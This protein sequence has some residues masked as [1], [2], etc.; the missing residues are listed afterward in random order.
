MLTVGPELRGGNDMP[1][2]TAAFLENRRLFHSRDVD[3]TRAWLRGKEFRFDLPGRRTVQPD[4]RVNGVYLPNMYLGYLQYG[5]QAVVSAAPTRS[6]YWVH[7]PIRGSLDASFGGDTIACHPQRAVILSPTR[8]N[9]N[10]M[11]LNADCSRVHIYFHRDALL[12]QLTALLGEPVDQPVEFD[13]ELALTSGYGRSLASCLLLAVSDFEQSDA[14]LE[15]PIM[16]TMF[17]QFIL[18]G[19]L[20]AHAHSCS[21]RLRRRE[22]PIFP[23]DVKRAIDYM[24]SNLDAPLTLS[25][26]VAAAGV[27]GRTLFKH[28]EDWKGVSPMRYLRNVR[29]QRAREALKRGREG[30]SVTEV[31]KS[32]GFNHMSRFSAEYRK[33]FGESPSKTLGRRRC[34]RDG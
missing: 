7:L 5:V 8:D 9:Y 12:R 4:V 10:S 6:D 3:E 23:R 20:L 21:E 11:Q 16:M 18:T 30:T 25:D 26:I 1:S 17:E 31:A 24:E 27:P 22:R 2:A 13:P 33:R 15:N 34:Q 14:M 32:C 28:F 19:L 29:F